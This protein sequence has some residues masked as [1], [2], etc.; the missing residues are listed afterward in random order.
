MCF[1]FIKSIVM[2]SEVEASHGESLCGASTSLS[3]TIVCIYHFEE[4]E[5]AQETPQNQQSLSSH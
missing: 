4:R 5:I 2:L 1:C 3:L